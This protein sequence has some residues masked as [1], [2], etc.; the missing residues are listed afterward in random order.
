MSSASA[1]TA[2]PR[3]SGSR[4]R[5]SATSCAAMVCPV[6]V[7]VTGRPAS[8]FATSGSDRANCCT[9]TSRSSA[10]S[11][12][13]AAPASAAGAPASPATSPDERAPPGAAFLRDPGAFFARLG[14]RI[15]RVMTDNAK[16]YT[17]SRAFAEA[18][19]ELEARHLTTQ[20]FRPQTNGKSE[21][22]NRTMLDEWAYARPYAT[23]EERI[24]ALGPWLDHYN[25]HRPHTALGGLTPME[26][27]VNNVSV[28][29]I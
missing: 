4:A 16:N 2:W 12:T 6:C 29:H 14:V 13:A 19:A 5:R 20:P 11:P 7:T 25:H 10:G 28:N 26:V 22:F 3:S 9:W 17:R 24:A 27:L 18:L 21:R 1:R 15:E 23:N 8:R